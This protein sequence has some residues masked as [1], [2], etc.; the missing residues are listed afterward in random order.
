MNIGLYFGSFNPI[1][2]GHLAIAN[3]IAEYTNLDQIWFMV[4]PQNPLKPQSSL[5]TDNYRYDMVYKAIEDYPKFKASN[6]EFHLPKPSFTINTLTH[7]E[8]KYPS[9]SFALIMG[10]DNLE[11]FHKWKN[12]QLIMEK[13]SIYVY[14]RAGSPVIIPDTYKNIILVNAPIM[15][16]S[17]SFIRAAIKEGKNMKAFL[18]HSLW[19]YI[20]DM[21]FYKR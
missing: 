12:Y 6:F 5:L 14:P 13:Y 7:L 20:D 8:E 16:I 21:N 15:E 2:I 3:Y 19:E 1:H 11:T 18:P 10:G 4:S 9:H 17:S